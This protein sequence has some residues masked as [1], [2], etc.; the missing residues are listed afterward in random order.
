VDVVP[1]LETLLPEPE[2]EPTFPGSI[3][4]AGDATAVAYG[5]EEISEA[6]RRNT[7]V[8]MALR[9]RITIATALSSLMGYVPPVG[10]EPTLEGF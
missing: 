4:I 9:I 6:C 1:M 2:Y 7:N 3:N 8:T 10:L 5:E